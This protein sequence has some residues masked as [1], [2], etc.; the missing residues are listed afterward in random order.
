MLLAASHY[1]HITLP[2]VLFSANVNQGTLVN[3]TKSTRL[4]INMKLAEK[5]IYY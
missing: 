4:I 2:H 5:K 3:L 1:P